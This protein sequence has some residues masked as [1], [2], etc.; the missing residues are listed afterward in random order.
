MPISQTA[1]DKVR[2]RT[3][4]NMDAQVT[5]LRGKPG[6]LDE[7]TGRVSGMTNSAPIYDGKARLHPVSGQGS[8]SLG[9]GNV[10]Q[11]STTV[12]IPWNAAPVQRDDVVLVRDPGRDTQL[13]GAALRVVEV[14]GGGAFGDARRCSCTLWGKSAYWDGKGV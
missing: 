6:V 13:T 5:I 7:V 8:L 14:T 11:R 12:S 9:P 3:E 10:D 1:V 2:K 4:A